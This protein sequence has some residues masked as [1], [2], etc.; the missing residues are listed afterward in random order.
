MSE[1]LLKKKIL[2][3]ESQIEKWLS[4]EVREEDVNRVIFSFLACLDA[5]ILNSESME[6]YGYHQSPSLFYI[7]KIQKPRLPETPHNFIFYIPSFLN[8]VSPPRQHQAQSATRSW[9]SSLLLHSPLQLPSLSPFSPSY[10]SLS[11]KSSSYS[12]SSAVYSIFPLSWPCLIWSPV[13]LMKWT[14]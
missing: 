2:H 3:R 11:S 1:L 5:V 13:W 9:C 6:F 8:P 12:S 4:H 7:I 14:R 10:I